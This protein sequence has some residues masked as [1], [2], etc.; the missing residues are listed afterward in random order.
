MLLE[1]ILL[2]L[3]GRVIMRAI[4]CRTPR[5]VLVLFEASKVCMYA[6]VDMLKSWFNEN[7]PRF[8]RMD[9]SES[10]LFKILFA[11]LV[12]RYIASY[13]EKVFKIL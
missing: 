4:T 2:S 6:Y 5:I 9:G 13:N 3:A 1:P 7:Y 10:L 11:L 8:G 12:D